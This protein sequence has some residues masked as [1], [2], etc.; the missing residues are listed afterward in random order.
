MILRPSRSAVGEFSDQSS[1]LPWAEVGVMVV[2]VPSTGSAL[3]WQVHSILRV[4]YPQVEKGEGKD[5][6][7]DA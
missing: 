3:L 7:L 1:C 4:H 6:L 2:R 5:C